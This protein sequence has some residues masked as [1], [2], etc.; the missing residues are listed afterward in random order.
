[1]LCAGRALFCNAYETVDREPMSLQPS[2]PTAPPPT[3]DPDVVLVALAHTPHLYTTPY[4]VQPIPPI[5]YR[6]IHNPASLCYLNSVLHVLFMTH[7]FPE[8]VKR[9]SAKHSVFLDL[10]LDRL[11]SVLEKR[12]ADTDDIAKALGITEADK[13]EQR[14]A[15]EYFQ[16]ILRGTSPEASKMFQ[17]M[18]KHRVTCRACETKTKMEAQFWS[19]PLSLGPSPRLHSP[20]NLQM[21]FENVFTLSTVTG[22]DRIYCDHCEARQDAIIACS[23]KHLP[24]ILTVQLMRFQFDHQQN[25]YKK[26]TC[27]IDVP[28]KLH[29]KGC[30]YRLYAWINHY[31]SLTE[32][33]YTA[34][35]KSNETGGWYDFDDARV[36]LKPAKDVIELG[37]SWKSEGNSDEGCQPDTRPDV[38]PNCTAEEEL[39]F[40]AQCSSIIL[41]DRF[42][43]C[44]PLV[45]PV[46][47]LGNCVYD[48]CEYDGMQATLCD[49]VEAYAQAWT[50]SWRNSTFCRKCPPD[51]EYIECGPAC[52]PSCKDPSTNCTGSCISGCFCKPGFVFKGPRC[53]PLEKCGCLDDNNNYYEPGEIIYGNGCSKLC[54]CAGNY[55]LSCVDNSCDPTEECREINGAHGCYPKGTSTCVA[56]SDPHY[57]TFDKR[58]YN[59]MGNCSYVM[60]EPCNDTSVPHFEVHADNENRY[61]NPSISYV[62]AVHVYVQMQKISILKGG[63]VQLNGT[64]VNLPLNPTPGVSVFKSG[65]HYTVS[66]DFGVTVRYDGNHF[67]DIKVIK[68]Y[69]DKLCGLCGDYNNNAKDDFRKPDG[70]LTPNA[71]DFGHSWVTDPTC[72][73]KP[74][75][76]V[77]SCTEEEQDR[78]ESSGFCG[79]L[80]DTKGPFAVCHRKVNPNSYFKDCL[81]DLCELNG[82]RPILCEAIEAY[83]N[84]CQDRGVTVGT[85]RN[86]T[87]CPLHCGSNSHYEPC[88]PPCQETCSGRPSGC[89]GPCSE[90]CVCNPGYVLSAGKCVQKTSCGCK[91][92]TNGQYYEP[93]DEFYVDDCQLKC[94]CNAPFIT[95]QASQCPPQQEC[96]LLGGELGCYPTSPT[97]PKPSTPG[98]T[99]PKP[100]TPGPTT[101]RPT[102]GTT[103]IKCPPDA[104]YIECGPACIPSC[105]DPST[106]CTGSCISGCFCKPGFVFKDPRCVPLEK[107]GCLDDNNNYYEP[108]EI[109]YGNGCSKLCRCAGNYTLS[110]VDN[111]CDPTEECREINGAHG[112]YPKGTSTCVATS[113]PHYT[114]FDKRNYNFMGNCSYVMSEPC[115]DTSVPHFEVH[116]DNENRYNNPSI[117]YVKAVHVYVRTQK[118]SILKGGT[119]QLNGTNVN[120]PLNPTP[121][122]SVF[123][124]GRHYTVSMDFGVTVRYDGNHFMD[125][126]V[127]KDYQDKLC[128]L[129]GDYNN[130]AKDDFRK[131]DG[132]LTPNVNDFGHSWVTDPTCNAK[133]NTT[134]PSCTE[135]EQDRYESS[136]FCG[137]LLDTKGPF[138]VCHRK[139]NP[140]SYFK[141]CL[142]D[143]CELNGSRP[144]LCEAIEAYVNECQDRGVTVG[145]WR[146]ETFCP[147][148]CGPNSHY[149]PCAPPCQETC[150]G[151]PS[152]CGGPCSEGCVCNPGYVLSAGKCVQKTS[153]GCN[154]TTNGQYYEPGD[155]FYVDDCQLKC[156]CNAPFIT[157]QASQCPPQQECK[158]LGGE[159]GCYPTSPTTPKPSTPGPTTPKPSTPGPTTSRPTT[160]TTP[161]KCPPDAEYIECGPACIPSCKDPSTN[162][163][164]SCISGCFCKPGFVFKDPRCVPL[165]K[166]GCLDDNNNY[167]EPGEIIYGNGCSK[168]CRCAGNYTLSCVDNSCDPTE[169]CREINGAHGCYPKDTST[170][171]ATSDPHYTTFDKL[172]YTFMGNCSYLMS[173]PCNDTSV[174]HF[175]VHADNENRYNNP[176]ISYV[177]AVHVYVRMQKISI[178]KGGT[179]Q[180]NGTNV[181]LPLNPTPGVS[182]FMS[183]RHYT[184]SMDFGVT[185]RYD[186]NHFMDIKVIKDY[187]DKLCG[188]CGD[189]NNNAKDDFRKPDGS[190]TP[191][192]NDFGHSW[193]TDPTCN[194]KPNTTVPSCTEEEQDRYE[195][196]GFCGILLDTK[197]P[198][199]VCHRKVN[200]NSYFKDCLFDLCELNGSRPI[201]CEAIEAYVNECQDRGVT[202]GTW[203]NE[204]FC[205]LQCGPN[206]HYEPCA[207]PC[208]D[209]CSGRPSGCGGPCSEACVC[210]PGYVLSAGKCVQKTSCGCKFTTNGQYYEPG[211]EFYVDDCQLKCKCNAPFITC[212]ASQCPPQQ[213]CK[214]LGGELGCYPTS[215]TTPKPST[216]GPTTPKPSTPGPTTSRPTTGTTP[217]K[218]P[219]DAEYIECGPACIPSCKD[220]STNCTG[221]CIS[222]CF[223]KLGFVFKDRRC[224]PLEKCGCLD[225]NNNYYEP[226]EI[227]YGNGCSKLCRCAGNYTL[228]CVD[229]SCDPT[230]ECREINGAH[231]CYPK[232]TSTCVAHSD[233]H[234]TTFDKRNYNFMGNCSYLMSEP[235]ND[236]SVPHFEVH[237][238]NENRYNNPSISYVKAVHV[239]VRT[240]K[241]SILKGGTVQLNGT[242]VNLPL[243]PTPGVSVFMSGRH[244]TVSMD[245]G[246]TVRY[247]GNHFMDIKVIKDYQD[248]LCGLCGDYN[249]NAKDDFRKPDGSLTPNAN[250]FG[251]S[252][253]TDPT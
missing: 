99:T 184:V 151:R 114:T 82:S 160:G 124:S 196:S 216:P 243:N 249:N 229:N 118:I 163:T 161:I 37:N 102:T 189:Y 145:T 128:G 187:Q 89:G 38:H 84:E 15:A 222:G 96:K 173:E 143:L 185:V 77:P 181:N 177:K 46:A 1:M 76:T 217:I 211:D 132:S 73:A 117:S 79:I 11:F 246:V 110:C 183:G 123:M 85:W 30:G 25:C 107:C 52:I 27:C 149:E 92:T 235:C 81:F 127:I 43:S 78:Y 116:A 248:K 83:V 144:I 126:K 129:C 87:F 251:H 226:G 138:A 141:D 60:S 34:T 115:N 228:S 134:V 74:N 91:F 239:Y 166:C 24:Q 70:S 31:G 148:Q 253:V 58:N 67:M 179:V 93:G 155:E 231:G 22:D 169:E 210:N 63:T 4:Q 197:G 168:L 244:Y 240:Q 182:V 122:V 201:L 21:A 147:L 195:S 165:E 3:S 112:C 119:V 14:D 232:D 65:R 214:L 237:A 242:N 221:S 171:V 86:E 56:T 20:Y 193:V 17:G 48:M 234:Y 142:F 18:L 7:Q 250:D 130:N 180:L 224:V 54:R 233:P 111:S 125:I 227:I 205:P 162:C 68:D 64:N 219:P 53:V 157:C 23:W 200:P 40:D 238:D 215:P 36:R 202:V 100:S 105:K 75:T 42:K 190:L 49:N 66:M 241:I 113:D 62:K 175:E 33:H 212:Q 41:S 172:H 32:G 55:T 252:W 98:P 223:C 44:H 101:S 59:F 71:N 164:G 10:H 176:S 5:N 13:Y 156:K 26:I 203:R 103:P 94:K 194:A 120:L 245:F 199:A 12:T 8:A 207:P 170:C 188:L 97:T 213:E 133:P 146:N 131:P 230:E 153:C 29:T 57:T 136:G 51:A 137:I 225:D 159:L 192:A 35:I 90:A 186:G 236:T 50:I 104:E 209:T 72:N 208:Q 178:L 198:F 69:Q 61:N 108:G 121:G 154:F 2:T 19:L 95:C 109:I 6:G 191:N 218:C 16:K 167:Y 80:L 135:E 45:P 204:T 88:A 140:N 152:G 9:E 106:N 28:Q 47:F 39:L 220:P 206:S 158:L 139:V 150:S 174:P 247:D